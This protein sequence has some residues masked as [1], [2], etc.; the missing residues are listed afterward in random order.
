MSFKLFVGGFERRGLDGFDLV[1]HGSHGD[2]GL[3]SA[4]D[5]GT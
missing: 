2:D 3:G 5:G 4:D 1:L